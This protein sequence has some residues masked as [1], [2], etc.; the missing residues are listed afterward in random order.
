[1]LALTVWCTLSGGTSA[2]CRCLFSPAA[3]LSPV[4]L[5]LEVEASFGMQGPLYLGFFDDHSGNGKLIANLLDSSDEEAP[6]FCVLPTF[7]RPGRVLCP[8]VAGRC[9][10][11]GVMAASLVT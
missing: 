9:G 7:H 2:A 3:L 5:T 11:S 10:T 8:S 6:C 4:V 1:M